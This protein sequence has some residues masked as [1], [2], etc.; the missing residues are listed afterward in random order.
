MRPGGDPEK[1]SQEK[2]LTWL[3]WLSQ[4]ECYNEIDRSLKEEERK[5]FKL[6]R[7]ALFK[8]YF[9]KFIN[10][11]MDGKK[12]STMD[13]ISLRRDVYMNNALDR[14]IMVRALEELFGDR[15]VLQKASEYQGTEN[16]DWSRDW[17][18]SDRAQKEWQKRKAAAGN[19]KRQTVSEIG[20][21]ED[22]VIPDYADAAIAETMKGQATGERLMAE[23]GMDINEKNREL[24][25][26]LIHANVN[27][28]PE[29]LTPVKGYHTI[30]NRN[31]QLRNLLLKHQ[32]IM[33]EQD[34]ENNPELQRAKKLKEA[35]KKFEKE[36]EEQEN[37]ALRTGD[38]KKITKTYGK[39]HKKI[40]AIKEI[41]KEK[42][43]IDK[44]F[45]TGKKYRERNK[46]NQSSL[47]LLKAR[48]EKIK[49]SSLV[50]AEIGTKYK[51]SGYVA[52]KY[53]SK[54]PKKI[55]SKRRHSGG[56]GS[57]SNAISIT[58]DVDMVEPTFFSGKKGK[59]PLSKT[60]KSAK[61]LKTPKTPKIPRMKSKTKTK[62]KTKTKQKRP[63]SAGSYLRRDHAQTMGF[64]PNFVETK[65]KPKAK[66]SGA[67]SA[68][69]RKNG[70]KKKKV[71]FA[72][73]DGDKTPTL[74]KK[75]RKKKKKPVQIVTETILEDNPSIDSTKSEDTIL[76]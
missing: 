36:Q 48:K 16:Y 22:Y 1:W 2:V 30:Q 72:V 31:A 39:K 11:D 25:K 26:I 50:L 27:I 4:V 73:M 53:R 66:P 76:I 42:E 61:S 5:N 21:A 43:K 29:L 33:S 55:S 65:I 75:M 15:K 51:S 63:K 32:A 49:S 14:K 69:K 20:M 37:E 23:N 24:I 52:G 3:Q 18:K 35:R 12:L 17:K 67:K 44:K 10:A 19:L 54:T 56:S 28:P 68:K 70:K 13:N 7:I 46:K 58:I 38:L 34:F 57:G 6:K 74:E 45:K 47:A 71:S 60:A 64:Q 40:R 9:E 62:T 59:T 41:M 8:T